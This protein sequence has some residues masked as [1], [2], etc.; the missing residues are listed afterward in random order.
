V[1][2][3]TRASFIVRVVQG[4]R[5]KVSGVIERVATGAKEA[6]QGVEA[7]GPV[8]ARMLAREATNRLPG[9]ERAG[10]ARQGTLSRGRGALG[11]T[12]R[13]HGGTS[14]KQTN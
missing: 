1:S 4:R 3:V 8:I 10:L 2:R 7:I 6:F 12:S 11:C 13:P 5:G 9:A 14:D